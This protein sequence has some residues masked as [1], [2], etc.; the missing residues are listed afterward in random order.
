MFVSIYSCHKVVHVSHTILE[1]LERMRK[2]LVT[3]ILINLWA[4]LAIVTAK[5]GVSECLLNPKDTVPV[6]NILSKGQ[7]LYGESGTEPGFPCW[8]NV[9]LARAGQEFAR[10]NFAQI[11]LGHG[12]GL[13]PLLGNQQSRRVLYA[14]HRS[15]TPETAFKRYTATGLHIAL[16][17]KEDILSPN[18]MKSALT[19]RRIHDGAGKYFKE[20][21][22]SNETDFR[23]PLVTKNNDPHGF[24]PDTRMWE[25]FEA[26]ME[27]S[28]YA[29][30][31]ENPK[32]KE[33][34]QHEPKEF[35][36]QFLFSITQWAFVALPVLFPKQI[37]IPR[38]TEMDLKGFVH[39]WAVLC[40]VLG[41]DERFIICR[42]PNDFEGCKKYL[43]DMFHLY[44][45]PS[46][47]DIDYEG[48][49]MSEAVLR[50]RSASALEICA[51]QNLNFC[52]TLICLLI[53]IC[54][55]HKILFV[56]RP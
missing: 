41:M 15:N 13:I 32:L 55:R 36:N 47:F 12:L 21:Q 38:W 50:V 44:I 45:V 34:L 35:Y 4:L 56:G 16:W 6:T 42:D 26:D 23:K 31:M 54:R 37:M 49:I 39:F 10:K 8:F 7:E 46:L 25:A 5:S 2:L 48:Q 52:S 14:T 19:I 18:W 43:D 17:Y 1:K 51:C 24:K 29:D 11:S 3:A 9:E 40:Y 30:M 27:E 22:T 53:L 28:K 33:I 20:L